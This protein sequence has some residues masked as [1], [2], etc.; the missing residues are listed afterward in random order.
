MKNP[1]FYDEQRNNLSLGNLIPLGSKT[2]V[3][4][5]NDMVRI[6]EN[7][8]QLMIRLNSMHLLY[9]FS[10]AEDLG[11]YVRLK[12]IDVL[13]NA[14][15]FTAEKD[16]QD[17]KEQEIARLKNERDRYLTIAY[18]AI[19]LGQLDEQYSESVLLHELGC[20]KAEY[21]KIMG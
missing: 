7:V 20:T 12:S 17:D 13:G 14:V 19:C 8:T 16:T 2:T 15:F 9:T 21:K 3:E 10:V 4:D 5:V 1:K 6:S 18:N 11:T